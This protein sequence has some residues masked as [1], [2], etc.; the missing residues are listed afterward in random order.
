[1]KIVGLSVLLSSLFLGFASEGFA[2]QVKKRQTS[3]ANCEE[4]SAILDVVGDK[5]SRQGTK[6]SFIIVLGSFPTS[7]S[8]RSK[9]SI[10]RD[11]T[12]YLS[13]IYKIKEERI[14]TGTNRSNDSRV[15]ELQFFINGELAAALN[16]S[17]K[18]RLCFGM[19]ETFR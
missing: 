15:A 14:R 18:S 5:F 9:D 13:R 12:M 16:V 10:I 3:S 7:V 11:A 8:A 4:T 19:G 17:N 6:E 1:M 2:Q